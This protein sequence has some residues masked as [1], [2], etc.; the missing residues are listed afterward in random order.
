[1]DAIDPARA[2]NLRTWNLAVGILHLV[3]GTLLLLLASDASLP[4]YGSYIDGPPASAELNSGDPLFDLPFAAATAAFLYL[5]AIDHLIVA[6]PARGWY[7]RGLARG[8]NYARWAE[9]SISASLMVVLI[10]MLSGIWELTALIA[11]FG[12]NAAMIGF[13]A[14][15]ERGSRAGPDADW[16]PF[17]IGS[18][19]GV[20]PWIAIGF[21]LARADAEAG[22]PGF[23][24]G[25][26]F[27]LLF[28]FS[29]FPLNMYLQYRGVGRWSDYLV[30]EKTYIV[31]SLTAKTALAWQV[32]AGALAS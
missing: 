12:A 15:M 10:A 25:I 32:Y 22:V 19:A 14:L 18:V 27:S 30:G 20:V 28:L 17:W 21:Q 29:L 31:L 5:A 1:M 23:V 8:R 6:G 7:E 24:V 16:W 11:I 9:Y 2:S 26:F 13:G 4:V 3:S